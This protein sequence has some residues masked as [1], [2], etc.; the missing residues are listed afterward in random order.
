MRRGS[1]PGIRLAVDDGETAVFDIVAAVF[2]DDGDVGG[3]GDAEGVA[4]DDFL[5]V[6]ADGAGDQREHAL[7][8]AGAGLEEAPLAAVL[9]GPGAPGLSDVGLGV[10]GLVVGGEA[11]VCGFAAGHAG[12]YFRGGDPADVVE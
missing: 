1:S 7:R 11:L 2:I 12:G 6:E 5:V 9:V 8:D 3:G 10:E 4:A